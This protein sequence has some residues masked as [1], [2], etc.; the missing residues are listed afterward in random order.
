MAPFDWHRG[1]IKALQDVAEFV[2]EI[3]AKEEKQ[4]AEYATT[5]GHQGKVCIDFV[6]EIKY[7]RMTKK[8]AEGFI[9]QIQCAINAL[10]KD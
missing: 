5:Y 4:T 1:N 10:E 6:K 7:I 3:L 8:V 2:N 9:N